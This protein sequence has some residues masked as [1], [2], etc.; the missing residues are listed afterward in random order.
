MLST[1]PNWILWVV[2]WPIALLALIVTPS[3]IW[4]VFDAVHWISADP[5]PLV[6]FGLGVVAYTICWWLIFKHQF[7]GSLFS[8]AEHEF[9]HA[10]FA[11]L[12]LHWVTGF[13]AT[14]NSGGEITYQG[15]GNWLITS[16]PYWFPTLCVPILAVMAFTTASEDVW[17]GA[18][19]G[20]TLAYHTTSTWRE[21]SHSAPS[22]S[23]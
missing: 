15:E 19:L 17:I 12:T 7:S 9:T 20:A 2:K 11:W 3:V 22:S 14:W 8:T 4:T 13:R 21:E 10:I 18:G 23:T 5:D 1:I 6:G 16:A